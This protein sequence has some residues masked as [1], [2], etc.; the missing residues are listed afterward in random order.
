[1]LLPVEW[2]NDFIELKEGTDEL[3]RILTMTGL[4]VEGENTATGGAPVFEVNITPNRPDCLSVLGVARELRAA[5]GRE[6][7]IPESEIKEEFKTTFQVIIDSPLCRRYA[8]RVIMGITIGESP[9]WIKNRLERAGIRSINNVVDITNYVLLE[10]GHPLHAFDLATL[11]NETI[12]VDT[13]NG[14]NVFR[15]LDGMERKLPPDS[16]MIWDGTRPVAIAGIMGGLDTEVTENT[17]DL[18]LESAFFEP[19]SIRRTSR[20]IGLRTE[21]SYRFE[22]GTDIEG[23]ITALDRAAFLIKKVCGG[24]VSQRIDLY[25]EKVKP[26]EVKVRFSRV[27]KLLGLPVSKG[28]TIRILQLLGFTISGQDE[29]GAMLT[30]P[31]YRV[32]IE[33]ETDIMEE[34]ARHYGYYKIPATLPSA[35]IGQVLKDRALDIEELKGLM[36][37]SGFCEAVNYSFLNPVFLDTLKLDPADFR[38][39]T[40]RILNPIS[41]DDSVLRTFLLPSLARNLV[42]N[43]NQ[44]IR[45]IK[46]FEMS[47]VF[48]NGKDKLPE[49]RVKLGGVYLYTPGQHLWEDGAE[50]FFII[51]GLIEKAF[52]IWGLGGYSFIPTGEPFLHPGRSAD[53]VCKEQKIGFAGILSPGVQKMLDLEHFRGEVGLFELDLTEAGS[54]LSVTKKF[55]P[56]PRFPYIQRNIALLIDRTIPSHRVLEHINEFPSELIEDFWIFDVYEGENIGEGKKSLGLTIIYRS[57]ERTLTDEEADNVHNRLINFLKERTGGRLRS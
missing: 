10:L 15:T 50:T 52:D 55:Q 20:R 8:G 30:V 9:G 54:H 39:N 19:S 48:I 12:R 3:S 35:P 14:S 21:A 33:N 1:M 36:I 24:S 29:E 7:R 37:S 27:E 43:F 13:A 34:I 6:I 53:I 2:L 41:T 44:G 5:T 46:L 32:D 18:F 45:D 11:K 28:D 26:K 23:L 25:P 17:T 56:L 40:V 57:S 4:E 31:S 22:R 49:E 38:R 51:K 16:L 42:S 47:K